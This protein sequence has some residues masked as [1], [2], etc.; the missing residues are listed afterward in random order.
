MFPFS[1]IFHNLR[2]FIQRRILVEV[3]ELSCAVVASVQ[4]LQ[5]SQILRQKD[6]EVLN[7]HKLF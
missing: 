4:Y 2:D 5:N 6:L 3:R 1:Y 7:S